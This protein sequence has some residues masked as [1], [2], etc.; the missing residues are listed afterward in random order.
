[1]S[2]IRR[3]WYNIG[4]V[5]AITTTLY[6]AFAWHEMT[7]L[8]ILLL[9]NFVAVLIHQF[10][11]YRFPGGF[12][13][14]VNMAM[15]PSSTPNRYPLNQNSAMV[16]NV[17]G[18]YGFY[19]IPVFFPTVIWLGLAPMLFGILQFVVHGIVANIKLRTIYS[20]GLGAAALLHIP[21]GIY[22]IYYIHITGIVSVWDWV[23]GLAYIFFVV[24]IAE[25]AMTFTWLA[26]K[27]SPFA[28]SEAEMRRFNVQERI[29]RLNGGT[30]ISHLRS[31]K[32]DNFELADQAKK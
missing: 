14:I 22:Y 7:I 2:F 26:D 17:L 32:G 24:F 9:S 30:Y 12:P 27:N 16:T 19:L 18:A 10:E 20:P 28:F 1:M 21:I 3:N 29:E 23:I 13:A 15:L 25:I 31:Q 11:E 5:V 8:Q 4:L 6:L